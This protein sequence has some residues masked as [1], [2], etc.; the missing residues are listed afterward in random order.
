MDLALRMNTQSLCR[1]DSQSQ[2]RMKYE[3]CQIRSASLHVSESPRRGEG[4]GRSR[5]GTRKLPGTYREHDGID[6]LH[7][8]NGSRLGISRQ[9]GQHR[10]ELLLYAILL[11]V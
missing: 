4:P 7:I 1:L 11:P 2:T 3:S 6:G 5:P 10:I 9:R 8:V